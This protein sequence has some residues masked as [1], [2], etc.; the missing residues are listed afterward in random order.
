MSSKLSATLADLF[1]EQVNDVP[2]CSLRRYILPGLC[3]LDMNPHGMVL[4]WTSPRKHV[5]D[6]AE[7]LLKQLE[8]HRQVSQKSMTAYSLSFVLRSK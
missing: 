1:F 4:S 5:F 3:V 2:K 8:L 7:M 6:V